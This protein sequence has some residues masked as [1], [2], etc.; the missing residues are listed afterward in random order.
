MPNGN[1][2]ADLVH[3]HEI[4]L[5]VVEG[6]KPVAAAL[7]AHRKVE[8]ATLRDAVAFMRTFADKCHHGKEE[9]LLFPALVGAGVPDRGGPVGVLK[10]E[11]EQA[12]ACVGKLEEATERYARGER[13]AAEMIAHA[14]DCIGDLY[15]QH[16]AKENNVLFPMAERVL[17]APMLERLHAKFEAVEEALGADVHHRFAAFAKR[18]TGEATVESA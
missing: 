1:A 2:I 12:R 5:K 15:P 11:H 9:D 7:R 16:I 14:I 17:A 4:I 6:L 8:V 18:L 10:A 13:P 3:E